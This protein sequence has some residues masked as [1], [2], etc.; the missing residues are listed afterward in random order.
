MATVFHSDL[1]YAIWCQR[2]QCN[3][4][5]FKGC[6]CPHHKDS[7]LA[8][9]PEI[10][11]I[12]KE[13][14]VA[15][16]WMGAKCQMGKHPN[17]RKTGCAC[18]CH[19]AG[20]EGATKI[21][22]EKASIASEEHVLELQ[23]RIYAAEASFRYYGDEVKEAIIAGNQI[24]GGTREE[25]RGLIKDFDQRLLTMEK[26]KKLEV[27]IPG[28]AKPIEVGVV[29]KTFPDIV[30]L[31]SLG[32]TPYVVGPA[33]GGKSEGVRLAT[34]AIGLDPKTH[35]F[36]QIFGAQTTQSQILGYTDANG[37]PVHSPA[38]RACTIGGVWFADEV[39]AAN[40]GVMTA[41]NTI[42]SQKWVL[43][44]CC[45]MVQRHEKTRF[46]VA[47]NTFGK[48]ADHL[49]VGRNQLDAATLNRFVW[50]NWD[51]DWDLTRAFAGDHDGFTT[52]VE[53][54]S[55]CASELKLRVVI[56]PRQALFGNTM[57]ADGMPREYVEA[58]VIWAAIDLDDKRKILATMER[59]Y[60]APPKYICDKCLVA[61]ASK[62]D[63]DNEAI[64]ACIVKL[65]E[66]LNPDPEASSFSTT[67][68]FGSPGKNT[69]IIICPKCGSGD[70]TKNTEFNANQKAKGAKPFPDYKCNGCGWHTWP[71]DYVWPKKGSGGTG[72]WN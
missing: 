49:Y 42:L 38:C 65:E 13:N 47:A 6:E 23:E 67:D 7:S 30:R 17:C 35:F 36:P 71:K 64:H 28:K 53:H 18:K 5:R 9:D 52:Y 51:Y 22:K 33:G 56:G 66:D 12:C 58:R 31:M 62:A 4:C 60:P 45:G 46:V 50:L 27:K 48:G 2:G 14:A 43:F 59:K 40:P 55:E 11:A 63:F 37:K 19:S 3:R 61:F 25:V 72:H 41:A 34:M 39:D 29:H 10:L 24:I 69:N 21:I 57:L 16:G 44:Q 20:A 15:R 32:L 26:A 1:G 54:L 68:Q 8:P 70:I